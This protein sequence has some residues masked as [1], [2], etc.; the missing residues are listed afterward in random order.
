M[1]F[2]EVHLGVS[3]RNTQ[4]HPQKVFEAISHTLIELLCSWMPIMGIG[5]EK[6]WQVTML[7]SR[8]IKSRTVPE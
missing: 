6:L 4:N 7:K 2:T 8:P 5:K 1:I 3:L